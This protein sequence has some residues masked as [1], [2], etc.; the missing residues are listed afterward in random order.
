MSNAT[1][2]ASIAKMTM[3]ELLR[4]IINHPDYL[5]DSY[6]REFGRALEARAYELLKD[7]S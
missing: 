6:Y 7:H 4:E 3:P 1:Y 2:I 5:T